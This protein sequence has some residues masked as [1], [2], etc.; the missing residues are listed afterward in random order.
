MSRD[1]KQWAVRFVEELSELSFS[2]VFNPYSDRCSVCDMEN[3]AEIRRK[4]LE[5][6]LIAALS[7]QVDSV[8][9][10][11]DLGYR[12]GR[13][14]GLALTDDAHLDH[15][16]R[17]FGG[18]PKL[19]R[20]TREPEPPVERTATV[21][22]QTLGA[23]RRPV[24]LWNVFPFHPHEPGN[25]MSNRCHT[26]SERNACR[27]LLTDLLDALKPGRVVAIG[28]DAHRSLEDLH[29]DATY[30][31]HPSYGGQAEFISGLE[32]IYG[33]RLA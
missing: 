25:E 19:R 33:R 4:N 10:A 16:A 18:L 14:T 31:R 32:S 3:A 17:Q 28:R 6:V 23:I 21:V 22:W 29:I 2:D 13:R 27:H 11:R 1:K 20:A 7:M 15:H 24:F 12:G 9:V 5:R 8:W 30:V 26:R